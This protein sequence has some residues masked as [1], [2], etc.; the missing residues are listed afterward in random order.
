MWTFS[1]HL[2]FAKNGKILRKDSILEVEAQ[3]HKV[4]Y[5]EILLTM[6]VVMSRH[7]T[8]RYIDQTSTTGTSTIATHPDFG[9][10]QLCTRYF[11][12]F[13]LM[14]NK[15]IPSELVNHYDFV[16]SSE[17]NLSSGSI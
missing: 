11:G 4:R 5:G 1:S 14:N 2:Q 12:H 13:P 7:R 3:G 10:P 9:D 15:Y 16:N 6:P 17:Q 8:I